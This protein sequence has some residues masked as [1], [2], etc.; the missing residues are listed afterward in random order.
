MFSVSLLYALAVI[1]SFV[2]NLYV[3]GFPKGLRHHLPPSHSIASRNTLRQ[4]DAFL[5]A[6]NI[7]RAE[8][9]A[10]ALQW[11]T[12]LAAKAELWVDQC[13]FRHTNGVLSSGVYGENIAAGTGAFPIAA[14]VASFVADKDQYDSANP[15]YLHFTQVVWKSTTEVGCAVNQCRGIFDRSLGSASLYVCLY[16]PVGNVIG[17]AS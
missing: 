13:Q 6:H 10:T 2:P 12:S 8:H 1:L 16:N 4:I 17:R 7:I 9:N 3:H 14:A 11:S 5:D 15:T